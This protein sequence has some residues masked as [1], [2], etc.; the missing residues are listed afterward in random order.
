DGPIFGAL[1]A[2][3]MAWEVLPV[4]SG[5]R[6]EE[7]CMEPEA[8]ARDR[9]AGDWGVARGGGHQESPP[10]LHTE[11]SGEGGRAQERQRGPVALED[12]LREAAHT[13]GA[14]AHGGWGEAVDVLAVPAGGLPLLCGA[15]VGGCGVD[16]RQQPDVPD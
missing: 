3:A 14:D 2:V 10:C 7:G 6:E 8:Q 15:A 16:L 12:V 1:A 5:A 13:P 4:K 11:D 9:G